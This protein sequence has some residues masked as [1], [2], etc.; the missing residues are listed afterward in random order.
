MRLIK[1][2]V[3]ALGSAIKGVP[4]QEWEDG[5]HLVAYFSQKLLPAEQ[6]YHTTKN[7][8][9]NRHLAKIRLFIEI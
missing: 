6:N 3:D 1:I 8:E 5:W 9:L 2:V 7:E 4:Q